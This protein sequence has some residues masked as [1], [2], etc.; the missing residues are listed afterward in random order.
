MKNRITSILLCICLIVSMSNG[1]LASEQNKKIPDETEV[2]I[3]TMQETTEETTA[4]TEIVPSE[5]EGTLPSDAAT[6]PAETVPAAT[7]AAPAVTESA[8][9]ATAAAP[10]V[11]EAVPATTETIPE[12][13]E[14]APALVTPE[15]IDETYHALMAATTVEEMDNILSQM[16][17]ET[18][19]AFVSALT[20]GQINEINSKA[21]ALT[22]PQTAPV[23]QQMQQPDNRPIV[24]PAKNV[25]NAA[26]FLPPVVG[27]TGGAED[28]RLLLDP[29]EP[30]NGLETRKTVSGPD[31]NGQYTL[32]LE[33]W[34]TGDKTIIDQQTQ[35][36][37]DIILVLDQ[38]GSMGDDFVTAAYEPYRAEP[39]EL[40]NNR[41]KLYVKRADGSF[42]PVT[43]EQVSVPLDTYTSYSGLTNKKYNSMSGSFYHQCQTGKYGIV[44]IDH[45]FFG[46]YTYNCEFCGN[47]GSSTGQRTVPGFSNTFFKKDT[48]VGYT[49]SYTDESGT[50]VTATVQQ[51]DPSPDWDFHLS[52]PV[53]TTTR[54][55]ALKTAV[56]SFAD[57]VAEK[58]KGPDGLLGTG[59][60]VNHRI[61]MVGFGSSLDRTYGDYVN[62]EILIGSAQHRYDRVTDAICLDA[63]QD[64]D[65]VSGVNHVK[66]S[67]SVLAAEGGTYVNHGVELGNRIFRNHPVPQNERRN[68]IMIVFTDGQPG[69]SGYDGKVAQA[70]IDEAKIT[71]TTYG[72]TVYSVGIFEGAD[73]TSEGKQK[74]NDIEMSNWFMQNL[75]SNNGAVQDPSYYLSAA[76]SDALN[77]IFQTIS[78]NIETGGSAIQLGAETIMKDVIADSF[79]LPEGA[80]KDD[81][82]V[83]TA[84]YIGENTFDDGVS[85]PA[86]VDILPDNRTV[87]VTNFDYSQNWVGT[88]TDNGQVSYRGR[89]LIVEI[90]IAVRDGFL[91]GNGVPTNGT[92]SGIYNG[93]KIIENF[94]VPEV[95][96]PIPKIT[97]AAQDRNVYLLGDLTQDQLM[98]GVTITAGGA[99]L[100]QALA[101]WQVQYV[102]IT[103]AK[104]DAM[105]GLTAD[106]TYSVTAEIAPKSSNVPNP[107]EK[108][109]G[110]GSANVNVFAPVLTFR[111]SA[112]Y[113]GD[114]APAE[115]ESNCVSTQWKHEGV[116]DGEV[117]M[118][119]S[120][121]NLKKTYQ[122]GLGVENGKIHTKTD[123][124]VHVAVGIGDQDITEFVTYK[125]KDCVP[126]CGFNA[127]EQAFLL[128]VRTCQLTVHKQGGAAGEPYV[129]YLDRNGE[130][131]T[132]LT[133]TGNGTETIY[134]LPVGNYTLAEDADWAWGY[135]DIQVGPGV[136]LGSTNPSG[137]ITCTNA[138]RLPQWLSG[139]SSVVQNVLGIAHSQS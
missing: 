79:V 116:F 85:F 35:I 13:I 49:F 1:V 89:K 76:D 8:P 114:N 44:N 106:G 11:T 30:D 86:T 121:P 55:E 137:E 112:V 7:E 15:L 57:A 17:E 63:F 48:A 19:N 68:R 101:P 78:G 9:I 20:P 105:T 3:Q 37:T 91:G 128:H 120:A 75:S 94:E 111:D 42:V 43:V 83:Y 123:I 32:T 40:Y 126:D 73:A 12:I 51:S 139:F 31:A 131:Y 29:P 36:P 24:Y 103:I 18:A 130:R 127:A 41:E 95:N 66:S 74:G 98:Q 100:L 46:D 125:H 21:D 62:T 2:S 132:E 6:A 45:P 122:P 16:D 61:A 99:N 80:S 50:T 107:V 23:P 64:M 138:G 71:K 47:I 110:T 82:K 67:I 115:Y 59:D 87:C 136:Q 134:E 69:R 97:V 81:I 104:P 102:D 84:D 53:R 58:A 124:P 108:V 14:S 39:K 56:T 60:E 77:D 133:I 135:A 70:A 90:P 109:W 10:A 88:V 54:L 65:Q 96:V 4:P 52:K 34:A 38:S 25:T 72:A 113:Y 28:D 93:D 33:A 5:S 118:I 22:P 27:V 129:F 26:P 119:G 92:D 117:T